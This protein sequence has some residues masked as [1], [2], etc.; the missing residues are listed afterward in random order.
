M[1]LRRLYDRK[2]DDVK[3]RGSHRKLPLPEALVSR[4]LKLKTDGQGFIF[5]CPGGQPL[6]PGNVRNRHLRPVARK[7][8][9]SISGFHDFRHTRATELR[10]AGVHPKLVS[11][12]LGHSMVQLA[13]DVYD[14]VSELDL[15]RALVPDGTQSEE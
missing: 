13:L 10:R 4:L 12:V 14:H 1:V 5:R 7:L 9:I 15:R 11:A 3:S 6:T 2:L 8:G